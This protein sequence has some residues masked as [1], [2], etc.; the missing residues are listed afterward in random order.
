MAIKNIC[1]LVPSYNESKT[2]GNIVKKLK[3]H[4]LAVYVVDDGSIDDTAAIASSEGAIVVKNP[5]NMGKGA[6]LREGFKRVLADGFE[7]VLILDGDDQHD[8]TDIAHLIWRMKETNAEMV[9]GNRMLD[10]KKMPRIRLITNRFMSYMLSLLS[11][12][13]VPDTQ[14]GFRLIKSE[15]LKKIKLE[16]CKYEIESEMIIKAARAGFKI[17]SVSIKTVYKDEISKINPFVDTLRFMRLLLKT[18]VAGKN[19]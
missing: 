5:Q 4:N 10:T 16:S 3:E 15:V 6:A 12:Q 17:E 9:I 19:G 1:S 7:M 13:Y 8:V 11:G 2:I 14:C 18:A